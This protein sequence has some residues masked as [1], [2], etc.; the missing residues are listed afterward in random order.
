MNLLLFV[1]GCNRALLSWGASDV[2][3]AADCVRNAALLALAALWRLALN[4][5]TVHSYKMGRAAADDRSRGKS[6]SNANAATPHAGNCI[7][8]AQRSFKPETAN[9][10]P[11]SWGI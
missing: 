4:G 6:C 8:E 9:L 10:K 3:S 5:I 1:T 2:T 7:P 11:F